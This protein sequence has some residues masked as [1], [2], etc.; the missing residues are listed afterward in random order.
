M[1]M[2]ARFVSPV[3]RRKDTRSHGCIE[4]KVSVGGKGVFGTQKQTCN[5]KPSAFRSESHNS[6]ATYLAKEHILRP[7]LDAENATW[8]CLYI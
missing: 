8:L 1:Q 2:V 3:A 5:W 6:T 4:E 7:L